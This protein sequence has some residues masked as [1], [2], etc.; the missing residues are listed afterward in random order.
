MRLRIK[1]ALRAGG[2]PLRPK[3]RRPDDPGSAAA[4]VEPAPS[5]RPLIGGA[6]AEVD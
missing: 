6:A 3:R 1:A 4:P 2:M 5:P